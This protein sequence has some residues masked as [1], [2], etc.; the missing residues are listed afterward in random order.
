MVPSNRVSIKIISFHD[1][2]YRL[3]LGLYIFKLIGENISVS[4]LIKLYIIGSGDHCDCA[5]KIGI[6]NLFI[7]RKSAS[8]DLEQK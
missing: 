6:L 2:T 8:L 3:Y 7:D 5:T 4:F 1:Y